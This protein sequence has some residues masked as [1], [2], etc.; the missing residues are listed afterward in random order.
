LVA[1]VV[2]SLAGRPIVWGRYRVGSLRATLESAI[3]GVRGGEN[4]QPRGWSRVGQLS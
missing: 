3:P 1:A 2:S 4:T